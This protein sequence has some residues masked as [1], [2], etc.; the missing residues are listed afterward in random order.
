MIWFGFLFRKLIQKPALQTDKNKNIVKPY[1]SIQ[2]IDLANGSSGKY[3]V[4]I[5]GGNDKKQRK[6]SIATMRLSKGKDI[7]KNSKYLCRQNVKLDKSIF[8]DIKEMEGMHYRGSLR[9]VIAPATGSKIGKST[10]YL[11]EIDASRVEK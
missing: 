11:F 8:D 2:S 3:K 4:Y 5:C 6:L 9:F 10:Q 7:T 1:N